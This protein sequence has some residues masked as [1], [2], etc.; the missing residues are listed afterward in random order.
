MKVN[1]ADKKVIADES[2]LD[3]KVKDLKGQFG[4]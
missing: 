3:D 4:S 2:N 1:L